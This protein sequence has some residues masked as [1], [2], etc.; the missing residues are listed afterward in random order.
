MNQQ[1]NKQWK[2]AGDMSNE[3]TTKKPINLTLDPDIIK[4]LR[5]GAKLDGRSMSSF[6]NR[7]LRREFMK[8]KEG[9]RK[10]GR[11]AL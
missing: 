9:G 6:L 1:Q 4:T 10:S 11:K 5:Q 2:G 8:Q 7:F 3:S